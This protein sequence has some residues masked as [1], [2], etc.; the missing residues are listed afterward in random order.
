VPADQS[1]WQQGIQKASTVY[2]PFADFEFQAPGFCF[3]LKT[4]KQFVKVSLHSVAPLC[5]ETAFI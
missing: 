1:H 3:A 2:G 5:L 4:R